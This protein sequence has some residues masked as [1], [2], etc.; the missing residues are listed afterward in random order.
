MKQLGLTPQQIGFTTFL[1]IPH[2]LIPL[3]LF[4]GD[5]FRARKMVVF[6]A[7]LVLVVTCFL[8]IVPLLISLPTCFGRDVTPNTTRE[9][10]FVNQL[11]RDTKNYPATIRNLRNA[12]VFYPLHTTTSVPKST[13]L[14]YDIPWSSNIF[15]LMTATRSLNTLF[16]RVSASIGNVATVT[17]LGEERSKFGSY[18]MWGHIGGC[19][20]IFAVSLFAWKIRINIC[21]NEV[22]G[23]F[24][25]Y[26]WACG[27]LFLSMFSFPWFKFEYRNNKAFPWSD[28]KAVLLNCHYA[29]MFILSFYIGL[30]SAFHIFWE[31]WYLDNLAASPLIIG[32][33][34][35]IRRPILALSIMMSGR[36]LSRIGELNTICLSAALFALSFLG[37]SFTRSPWLVIG[38]DMFQ[39]AGTAISYAAFTVHISKSGSKNCSGTILGKLIN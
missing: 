33:A 1:G 2:L 19:V 23:F 29:F 26:I 7:T 12:T 27:L 28:V 38:L 32:T 21:G 5:R 31:F 30:C 4:L 25:A 18:Y 39:A 3:C 16:E 15:L 22:H 13:V 6:V 17:Y 11:N 9:F 14:V 24:M 35:L 8:T 34:G 20:S 37:L 10:S 36:I